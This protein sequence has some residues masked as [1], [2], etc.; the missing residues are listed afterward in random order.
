[1]QLSI[2]KEDLLLDMSLKD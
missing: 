2:S 1:V